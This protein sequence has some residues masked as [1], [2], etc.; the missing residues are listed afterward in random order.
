MTYTCMYL[1]IYICQ[2]QSSVLDVQMILI[3][4]AVYQLVFKECIDTTLTHCALS[5]TL[6]QTLSHFHVQQTLKSESKQKL[7]F[8]YKTFC[9][10]CIIT[11]LCIQLNQLHCDTFCNLTSNLNLIS[12][13]Y[14]YIF[15]C[16][17]ESKPKFGIHLKNNRC[18]C[19]RQSLYMTCT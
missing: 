18:Y 10:I 8:W 2:P 15:W 6:F 13:Y 3:I 12:D 9:N 16:N 11:N 4:I 14:I 1:I 5:G 7:V 19:Q 17:C